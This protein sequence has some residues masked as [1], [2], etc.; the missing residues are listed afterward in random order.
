MGLVAAGGVKVDGRW[1]LLVGLAVAASVLLDLVHTP[2]PVLFGALLAG[3]TFALG[4]SKPLVP[5][6]ALGLL[7]QGLIGASIGALVDTGTMRSLGAQAPAV[8]AVSLLTLALSITIGQG[9]RA[10]GVSAATAAFAFIAGGASGIVAMARD[11]DADDGVVT[12][13]QY[14]RVVLIVLGMPLV[15]TLV[16][17]PAH[18]L[19]RPIAPT[20]VPW[21]TGVLFVVICLVL[22]LSLAR[23]T[24][25]PAGGVLG[26]LLVS[27]VLAITG[28]LGPV[29]VPLPLE[30]LG[31]ALVGAQVGLR[32]TQASVRHIVR[33]L[34]TAVGLIILLI[35]TTA[36]LGVGLAAVT[37]ASTLDGYLATTPGGL[38]AVLAVAADTGANITFVL[39]VQVIR[40][41]VMLLLAPVVAWLFRPGARWRRGIRSSP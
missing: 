5:P 9:L 20:T 30:N 19:G 38:F 15:T 14:L 18:G 7:G 41:L 36:A 21:H 32:F 3:M 1:W 33:M 11:L 2:S 12:V 23:W 24:P 39:A 27:V 31:Y 6:P 10:H 13:V 4:S 29:A 8:L 17:R 37:G 16:F 40:L 28:L 22:G 26:P 34:P 35:A 25:L